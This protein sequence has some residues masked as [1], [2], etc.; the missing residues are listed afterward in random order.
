MQKNSGAW[1][2]IWDPEIPEFEVSL[3]HQKEGWAVWA[4]RESW[5]LQP[6]HIA[7]FAFALCTAWP[8]RFLGPCRVSSSGMVCEHSKLLTGRS[9][10]G[11]PW[12]F[13]RQGN[14][15]TLAGLGNVNAL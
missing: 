13:E 4:L 15:K 1:L 9:V 7:G 14:R 11:K 3:C 12:L 2:H 5:C 8:A 10:M 6:S